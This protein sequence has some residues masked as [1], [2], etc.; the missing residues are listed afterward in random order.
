MLVRKLAP[1]A[2]LLPFALVAMGSRAEVEAAPAAGVSGVVP[3]LGEWFALG[4]GCRARSSA[5]GDVTVEHLPADPARPNVTRVRFHLDAMKLESATRAPGSSSKF[6]R[7]CSIRLNVNPPPGMKVTRVAARTSLATSKAPGVS[8]TEQTELL[9]GRTVLARRLDAL[10]TGEAVRGRVE[11][12]SLAPGAA[13]AEP[14]PVLACAESK[15]IGLN[16]T[17]IA[18]RSSAE[19]DVEVSLAGA[20]T[21]ELEAELTPCS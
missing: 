12:V 2:L 15:I 9:L 8:L 6:A 1:L 20:R 11:D 14:F 3:V 7:E 21:L 13:D 19:D 10:A 5:P 17:W 4:S 18:E 16:L